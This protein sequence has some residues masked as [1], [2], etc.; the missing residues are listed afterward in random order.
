V[1]ALTLSGCWN[2]F[3]PDEG[4]QQDIPPAEY[5]VRLN[6]ENV[7][8]N[9]R[10]A[11]VDRNVNEYLDCLSEDFIFYPDERDV[12][13]PELEIPPE[14]YKSNERIMHQNMFSENSNV[15]DISLTMTITSLVYDYGIP[16]DPT[17]DTCVCVV[18]VDLRVSVFGDLT[19]LANAQSQYNM[20]IDVDQP[21]NPPDPEGELWWEI[22]LWY[23]L[24]DPGPGRTGG[25][26][27]PGVQRVSLSE[28]KSLFMD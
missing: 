26:D 5:R 1:F 22:Y 2:P 20:R 15:E 14:W 13:D 4:D 18:D 6:P 25:E 11:Y 21:N 24:G 16:E 28:L 8:H 23:D 19:Y 9:I 27:E 10:T 3:A 12:Q 17:D 7:L